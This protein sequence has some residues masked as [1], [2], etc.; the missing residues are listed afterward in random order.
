MARDITYVT[1]CIFIP[2]R[3]SGR[4][5]VK[6]IHYQVESKVGETYLK[7]TGYNLCHPVHLHPD[8]PVKANRGEDDTA[9]GREKRW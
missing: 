6:M 2:M 9:P 5:G 3:P 4:I 1:R 8:E 7:G